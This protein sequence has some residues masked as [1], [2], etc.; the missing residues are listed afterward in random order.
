VV[1]SAAV[2]AGFVLGFSG[3]APSPAATA[4]PQRAFARLP[5]AFFPARGGGFLAR[6]AGTGVLLR[7]SGATLALQRGNRPALL[8][9]ELTGARQRA[10]LVASSQLPGVV[11]EFF[12]NDPSRWRTGIRTFAR[13]SSRD[14]YPGIDL[15]YRGR[16]GS[17]EY[18]FLVAPAADPSKIGLRFSGQR[19]LGLDHG[20]LVL[21]LPGAGVRQS[22]PRAFQGGRRVPARFVLRGGGRVGIE[23][24]RYDRSRPLLIDPTLTYSSYLGGSSDDYGNGVAVDSA[25][26]A[27]LV[28]ATSSNDFPTA[29][30]LQAAR[31]GGFDAFVTKLNAAGSAVVYSTY[32]GGGADDSGYRLAVDSGGSAYVTG[33]TTSMDFPTVSPFQAA[34]AGGF[35]AFV[36][37]LNAAGSALAY[38]SYLGGGGADLAHAIAVDAGGSAYVAG[39][40][41]STNFPTANPFQAASGG[42][43]DAFVT[44]VNAAGSALVYS[45]Y[46]GGGNSDAGYGIAL[47]AGGSAFV[48]GSTDSSDF[49]TASPFQA[50]AAGANDAFV[51]KL[52]SAG[53]ALVYSTYMGGSGGDVAK[54]IAV[55]AAGSAYLTGYTSS[56]DFPTL[57][58]FQGST[59]GGLDAFVTKVNAAGSTLVFSSY[60]GGSA[61][62]QGNGIA[63]DSAG[64]A[65]LTGS[66]DSTNF[67]LASPF[68]MAQ[69]GNG[70]AFVAKANAA[71]SGVVYSSYLGG[72]GGDLGA[73]I[74][75]DSGGSAYLTGYTFSGDFP[76][77]SPL[78]GTFAG[79]VDAFVTKVAEPATGIAVRSFSAHPSGRAVV[80]R[81]Q[82]GAEMTLLGFRVYRQAAGRQLLLNPRLIHAR[83]TA[84]GRSYTFR[85]RPPASVR[86]AR[87]WLEAVRIDGTSV[88]FGPL[89]PA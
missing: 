44:K 4:A 14:V 43:S 84:A 6:G 28:G 67:P 89:R 1:L 27:Y 10:H 3:R 20:D 21:A 16:Q 15:S 70:D 81:W 40:T 64:S 83:P 22:G 38:S 74:A 9:L 25:G 87:Y 41:N 75:V 17:L 68:Q 76:T 23:L 32:L 8:R 31:S 80:L 77:A 11:N 36:T 5:L 59:S 7:G 12:G 51:T 57:N 79:T 52:N 66:T 56:T 46:L 24:G 39:E 65:Y 53:S 60:L 34:L 49:P 50:A 88:R 33:Y 69:A 62:D 26:R 82:T 47:D 37:K 55:D 78:Q 85:D 86:S 29:S 42:S 30:P 58:P 45:T 35:D 13:L 61:A 71:G 72:S 54:D 73:G 19:R 63:V 2:V 18:D 48:S